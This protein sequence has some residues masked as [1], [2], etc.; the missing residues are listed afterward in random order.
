MTQPTT[1]QP[2]PQDEAALFELRFYTAFPGRRTELADYM[3]AVVVPFNQ[4]HGV[5][6]IASFVDEQD[7]DVY[8]WVRRFADEETRVRQYDAVYQDER[9]TSEIAPR[10][11]GLMDRDRAVVTRAIPTAG[12][13]LR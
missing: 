7:D 9:W 4:A 13:P 1:P 3:D 2:A 12:S 10:V 8:V 5:E 11:M 6:V